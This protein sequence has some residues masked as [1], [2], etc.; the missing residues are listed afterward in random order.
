MRRRWAS[1]LP[2]RAGLLM[3]LCIGLFAAACQSNQPTA[4]Q[5]ATTTQPAA[6]GVRKPTPDEAVRFIKLINAREEAD[7]IHAAMLVWHQEQGI[8]EVVRHWKH[9]Q[10]L[11]RQLANRA[12]RLEYVAWAT[13]KHPTALAE[14]RATAW[15]GAIGGGG[16]LFAP[17]IVPSTVIRSALANQ[18]A[19]TLPGQEPLSHPALRF[20]ATGQAVDE[21]EPPLS[22]Q[23]LQAIDDTPPPLNPELIAAWEQWRSE[24]EAAPVTMTPEEAAFAAEQRAG[25][26]EPYPYVDPNEPVPMTP[27]EVQ[28]IEQAAGGAPAF[29]QETLD[30]I[31]QNDP[32]SAPTPMTPEEAAWADQQR[33]DSSAPYPYVDPNEPVPLTPEESAW[34]DQQRA[35]SGAPYPYVDP[36]EPIP[37]TPEEAAWEAQQRADSGAPYPMDDG[38]IDAYGQ[39]IDDG[40]P[41]PMTPEEIAQYGQW[42]DDGAPIPMTPEEVAWA[43]QQRADSGA[44]YAWED[45]NAPIPLTPEEVAWLDQQRADSTAPVPMTPEE[46]AA[47]EAAARNR[48]LDISAEDWQWILDH[49]GMGSSPGNPPPPPPSCAWFIDHSFTNPVGATGHVKGQKCGDPT[50]KWVVDGTY[51]LSTS[52][53]TL[54][55][56]QQWVITIDSSGT[57]GTYT[58]STDVSGPFAKVHG[59]AS[60]TVTLTILPDGNAHMDFHELQHAYVAPN[61]HDTDPPGVVGS[62]DWEVGGTC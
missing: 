58:Y 14:G 47:V 1:T 12:A 40:A 34:L 17:R 22:Q 32:D 13:A 21:Q 11:V 29:S 18:C 55:G 60:G 36:N 28:A 20:I 3:I 15:V 33:A 44:P 10:G 24:V 54:K 19:F 46:I 56:T 6:T 35:D 45:P 59:T 61:A 52:G 23:V 31:A 62:F 26:G 43:D 4:S 41:V 57:T 51:Q 48:T 7:L 39:W 49:N 42:A 16:A 9:F 53:I 5:L 37:M 27:E 2:A 38:T 25:S 50:G 30:W 8:R